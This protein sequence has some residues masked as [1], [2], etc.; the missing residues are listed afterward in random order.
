MSTQPDL[1]ALLDRI[2]SG[3]ATETLPELDALSARLPGNAAVLSLRAEALRHAGR[4]G[5]AIQAYIQAGENGGDSRNWLVAG[6]LLAAER[7]T[8]QSLQCLLKALAGMPD[9]DE[10]LDALITT[11]FNGGRHK[12]GLDHARRQLQL[13]TNPSLLSRAALLLQACDLYDESS[14]AFKRIVA[15]APNDPTILGAALVP[16]R[17]TC[18]WDWI[19]S[20]QSRIRDYYGRGDFAAPQEYPLTNLTWCADEAINLGVTRAY[21]ARMVPRAELLA[22]AP[23]PPA[24][25]RLR[26]GYLSS[27]FRNHATMHLMAGVFEHHDR[28]RFEVFAYDY[29]IPDISEYR[30][31]FLD[32]VEHHVPLL[33]MTDAQAAARIAQD[34]LDILFD[35]KLYTGNG[36]SGIM[37][38]RPT[39]LQAAYIGFPGSAAGPDIDYV[40]SDRFVTPDSSAPFY[41][42]KF[43]RLPH[44][45]QC[46]DRKRAAASNPGTRARHGL[47]EH[48]IVFGAFNQSYKIDRDSFA[49]WMR[50]LQAVPDS[51]L[52]LLGQSPAARINL[53]RHALLARIDPARIIYADFADPKDHLA[54]L[55]L[56]DAVLDAMV[57]NGHTTTSDALWAGVPVITARGRHFASR[58]SESLLNAMSLPELVGADTDGMIDIARRIGTDAGYRTELRAKISANRL[59]APLFDTARLTRDLESGIERMVERHRGGLAPEH[60]DVPDAGPLDTQASSPTYTGRVAALRT[61]YEGCPLCGGAGASLGFGN[62]TDHILW[63]EPLPLSIEWMRCGSC[64]HIYSRHHWSDLGRQELLRN[65]V[66]PQSGFTSIT[67]QRGTWSALTDKVTG[68]LG[69][70]GTL[71]SRAERPV[72]IDVGCGDG[73]LL[74][75]V[76][77]YGYAAVGLDTNPA[78]V[79]RIRKLGFSAVAH[80]FVTLD[81]QLTPDV[82]SLLD[83]LPQMTDPR[84]ALRKAA[85]ILR[86]GGILIVSAPDSSSSVWKLMDAENINRYWRDIERHHI[87]TRDELIKLLQECG[88]DI[89]DMGSPA[90]RP[91][92]I[93][94]FAARRAL[95]SLES[96]RLADAL[97]LERHGG[98]GDVLM[99][100]GA[101]K[102]L[103][104]LTGRPITVVTAP[105]FHELVRSCPHVERVESDLS[106]LKNAYPNLRHANLNP[107]SF[108]ISGKPEIDAFLEA[109]EVTADASLKNVELAPDPAAETRIEAL[110]A[111]WPQPPANGKRILL[112]AAQGDPNRRWPLENWSA[113]AKDLLQQ[114]HQVIA[115][116]STGDPTKPAIRIAAEGIL[117]TVDELNIAAT[118]AL[119]RRSDALISVDGGPVQLAAATNIG[120]VSLY[121]TVGAS[122]V[123]PFRHGKSA[124][125]A[126]AVTPSCMFHPCFQVMHDNT[127]MAPYMAKIRS[128]AVSANEVFANWCPDNGSFACMKQQITV[129]MVLDALQRLLQNGPPVP[130]PQTRSSSNRTIPETSGKNTDAQGVPTESIRLPGGRNRRLLLLGTCIM[131]HLTL[132]SS[133]RLRFEHVLYKSHVHSELPTLELGEYDAVAVQLT[134][135]HI[136][137]DITFP[138]EG[139]TAGDLA[140][141][142]L[143]SEDEAADYIS[144]CA[145]ALSSIMDRFS[146]MARKKNLL[147]FS[148]IEPHRNYLGDLANPYS[149][150]NPAVIVR[151]LNKRMYDE[152][153]VRNGFFFLDLNEALRDKGLELLHDGYINHMS[154][155]GYMYPGVDSWDRQRLQGGM[156]CQDLYDLRQGL[157]RT[158]PAMAQRVSDALD[159]IEQRD[160][161]KLIIVDLDD[162]L[163][164]GVAADEDK[165]DWAFREGWPLG[166]AESLL[167]YKKRGGLL[168]ICSKNERAYI[169]ERF[170]RI[171]GGEILLDDFASIRI[172]FS[173]KSENIAEILSETNLL[174]ENALFIDDNPREIDEVKGS[175]PMLRTLSKTYLGWRHLILSSPATQVPVITGESSNRTATVRAKIVRDTQ[176]KTMSREEWLSSL[177]LQ[178]LCVDIDN[179]EHQN[180]ERA[181]ELLNKT[182]QFNTTGKRWTLG[183]MQEFF[184]QGGRMIGLLV[185]DRHIDN[186]LV[187]VALIN[188]NEFVQAVLSCRVFNLGVEIYLGHAALSQLLSSG[189]PAH[190]TFID[191]GKNKSSFDYFDR[192]GFNRSAHGYEATAVPNIPPWIN[193]TV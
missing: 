41:T 103:K 19:E 48:K 175:F 158:I 73:V 187:G 39:Q 85:K 107:A 193:A 155:V 184:Q 165:P 122:W 83:V 183:Q 97:C 130:P 152:T 7:A 127:V 174:P 88:F 192:L 32:A 134:L 4:P 58:V 74:T 168:A 120:I 171:C 185:R 94:L 166:F 6:V 163:W 135:R 160:P 30:Q 37:A 139:V 87:F 91:G 100:L 119:M 172:N 60:F 3:H 53:T 59:T 5:E 33:S 136:F 11:L 50:V 176:E 55:Q 52:W 191:T 115:I 129:P 31:R 36:R 14:E 57:C 190:A 182:N 80:D 156:D 108:G 147:F 34:R 24:N 82:L 77:D 188:S 101:A 149:L 98:L 140:W 63:H 131:E 47:P 121:S 138:R 92:Y 118:I 164:R 189:R 76:L 66:P 62:I 141:T 71:L 49:V 17:F 84:A 54:R 43:C 70:Y 67:A 117:S 61:A 180:F 99:V 25:R 29:T 109:F 169:E 12:E 40:V 154:H 21:V 173:P 112:H 22:P 23:L 72:W 42:E 106:V 35:L 65:F 8:E 151:E 26:I 20:L 125:N 186:G 146:D 79:E 162:T 177:K 13:S 104:Q 38:Y 150:M 9:S 128:G 45:Y 95:D 15:L 116:G 126:V 56:A 133:D 10:V 102:A 124:W 148:F 86:P 90:D 110:V 142:R 18:E 46:N 96:L 2:N 16:A 157:T 159:I 161:I 123:L 81:I 143:I 178:C 68:L 114:G 179:A 153:R 181:F 93:E 144:R 170:E 137:S 1:A 44:S 64:A 105:G 78:A 75:T 89:K 28:N 167:V 132:G 113:L 69:G 51:V 111:S 27:D 145:D